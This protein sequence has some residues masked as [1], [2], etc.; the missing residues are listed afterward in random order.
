MLAYYNL[1]VGSNPYGHI[2]HNGNIPDERAKEAILEFMENNHSATGYIVFF[3]DGTTY[4]TF[5]VEDYKKYEGSLYRHE[6][7]K[8]SKL[9]H[10]RDMVKG[11]TYKILSSNEDNKKFS[12]RKQITLNL[13]EDVKTV[14]E[15]KLCS[16]RGKKVYHYDK[17]CP[18]EKAQ[19]NPTSTA[20]RF[21][22]ADLRDPKTAQRAFN[23][24]ES[25][26]K[27]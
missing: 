25:M 3:L 2:T 21:A 27:W 4:D 15:C 13:N 7:S 1:A 14:E 22:S 5:L 20:F 11:G 8:N 16:G 26:M 17:G 12:T 18:V 6:F 23:N 9:M 19:N 24:G 10:I